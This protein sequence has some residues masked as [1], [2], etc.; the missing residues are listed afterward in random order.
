MM[1]QENTQEKREG[2]E[3]RDSTLTFFSPL[4]ECSDLLLSISRAQVEKEQGFCIL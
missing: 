2:E 4:A 3:V 1:S